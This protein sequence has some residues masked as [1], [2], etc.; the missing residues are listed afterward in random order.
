MS[1]YRALACLFPVACGLGS[2]IAQE[3]HRVDPFPGRGALFA[4]QRRGCL[5][6]V[7][8]GQTAVDT[9]ELHGARWLFR[10]KIQ[11]QSETHALYHEVG[12]GETVLLPLQATGIP[13]AW[14]GF[15]WRNR[16]RFTAGPMARA[17]GVFAHDSGRGE[18]LLFGGYAL[19]GGSLVM[20]QDTWSW[21]GSVWQQ[22]SGT[23]PRARAMAAMAF[24]PVRS[25]FVM[26]GGFDG[27]GQALTFLG[28]TWVHDG[29]QWSPRPVAGPSARAGQAMAWDDGAQR[30]VLHGGF[31]T[32]GT[33]TDTWTWDGAGWASTSWQVPGSAVGEPLWAVP[34][35]LAKLTRDEE[36]SHLW[37]RTGGTWIE[38]VRDELPIERTDPSMAFDRSRGTVVLFGGNV[39]SAYRAD[40]WTWDGRWRV[41]RPA[42]SPPARART[43]MQFHGAR[44]ELMLFGGTD[45]ARALDDTWVFDG[46]NWS[47]R[48][49]SVRPQGRM[50]VRLADDAA[51]GE[52][53]LFGGFDGGASMAGTWLWNGT[54]WRQFVGTEPAAR[55]EHLLVGDDARARVVLASGMTIGPGQLLAHS[56][57]WEWDGSNWSLHPATGVT[58]AA[59]AWYQPGIGAVALLAGTRKAFDGVAWRWLDQTA[60]V[61]APSQVAALAWHGGRERVLVFGETTSAGTFVIGPTPAVA[62][63]TGG[64]CGAPM[65]RLATVG[66]SRIGE[67]E[68]R[69]EVDAVLPGVTAFLLL[70]LGDQGPVVGGCPVRVS[71]LVLNVPAVTDAN[72][73]V[74]VPMPIP[75][76]LPIRGLQVFGQAAVIVPNGPAAGFALSDGWAVR[77]GD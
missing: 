62:T 40:T 14:D 4:D 11:R 22:L 46:T 63:S 12:S 25:E 19:V 58:I 1:M 33:L 16:A 21:N 50:D 7:D 49:V 73:R 71:S 31:A 35:G 5:V 56:D 47:P 26:F 76:L 27:F 17:N 37:Q 54:G 59:Q 55:H 67:L 13:R 28:D 45:G 60:I 9:W 29:V 20:Q 36:A 44:N 41:A 53:V 8:V 77:I 10:N 42:V 69:F 6:V 72:G 18:L 24:D 34:G 3:A 75:E 61:G 15:E 51:R 39:G 66:R 48:A 32:T 65:P 70:G 23:A 64:A 74:V 2:A 68:F 57:T 43:A 38:R 30:L 52:I